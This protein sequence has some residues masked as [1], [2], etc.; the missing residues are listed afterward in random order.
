[1]IG[2]ATRWVEAWVAAV[3]WWVLVL[4]AYL[5]RTKFRGRVWSPVVAPEVSWAESCGG[6]R[7]RTDIALS[8]ADLSRGLS[9]TEVSRWMAW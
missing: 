6:W 5:A 7:P 1:V 9:A 4:I 3:C 8:C 2:P